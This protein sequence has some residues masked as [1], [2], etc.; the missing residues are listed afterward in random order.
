MRVVA[1]EPPGGLQDPQVLVDVAVRAE[2]SEVGATAPEQGREVVA[3][4]RQ[5]GAACVAVP[6]GPVVAPVAV[7][8]PDALQQHIHRAQVGDQQ[9]GVDVQ[10]LLQGLGADDNQ[11]TGFAIAAQPRFNC[12]VQQEAVIRSETAMMQRGN[13]VDR[14]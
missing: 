10:R 6:R 7:Q 1:D 2:A 8:T 9:V 14:E 11:A 3:L 5:H 13:A 4:R 12:V